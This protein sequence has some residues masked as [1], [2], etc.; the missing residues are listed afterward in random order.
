MSCIIYTIL[1]SSC[2]TL[3]LF[4]VILFSESKMSSCC[5]SLSVNS[6]IYHCNLTTKLDCEN[7]IICSCK[8]YIFCNLTCCVDKNFSK[9]NKCTC[10]S[11]QKCNLILSETEWVKVQHEWLYLYQKICKMTVWLIYLQKQLDLIK[12][13]WEEIIWWKLQN[14]EELETNET[15]QASETVAVSSLNDFLLNML[16]NQVKVLMKFDL[17][18]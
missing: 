8:K 7:L 18:Y 13:C 4:S 12:S 1:L 9:C 14:I 3:S 11:F 16:F 15:K 17:A 2:L 6:L 10:A 5:T